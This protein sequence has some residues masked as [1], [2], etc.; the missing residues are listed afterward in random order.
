[1]GN[2][3]SLSSAA[4]AAPRAP[5]PSTTWRLAEQL[6][7]WSGPLL[8]GLGCVIGY[9]AIAAGAVVAGLL[10]GVSM[11]GLGAVRSYYLFRHLRLRNLA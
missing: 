3:N 8:L 1:M 2:S 7:A 10:L 5:Q 4:G 9:R 6:R 11:A